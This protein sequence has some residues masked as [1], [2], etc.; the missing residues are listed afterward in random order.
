[1]QYPNV[2]EQRAITDNIE[3]V[4]HITQR[5]H[6]YVVFSCA[7][8]SAQDARRLLKEMGALRFTDIQTA[9]HGYQLCVRREDSSTHGQQKASA[10]FAQQDKGKARLAGGEGDMIERLDH[11]VALA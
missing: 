6:G 5:A 11:E 1:M 2:E 8:T 7:G 9:Y 3:L 10:K 4:I